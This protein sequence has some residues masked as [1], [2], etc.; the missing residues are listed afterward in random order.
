MP[1][2]LELIP[3]PRADFTAHVNASVV[4]PR[5]CE[6]ATLIGLNI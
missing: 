5:A 2:R 3:L 1:V 6:F 4:I